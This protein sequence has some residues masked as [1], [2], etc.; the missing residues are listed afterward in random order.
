MKLARLAHIS[1][2]FIDVS[3]YFYL[4]A[5]SLL[6]VTVI[7][8]YREQ[9]TVTVRENT[10][11]N[12]VV[13]KVEARTFP[14]KHIITYAL[15]SENLKRPA[16]FSIN[17]KTGE[18]FVTGKLDRDEIRNFLLEVQASFQVSNTS[19]GSQYRSAKSFVL[20]N[21]REQGSDEGLS[22]TRSSYHLKVPCNVSQD[23]T[24]DRVRTAASDSIGSTRTRFRFQKRLD[25][26]FITHNGKIKT[27]R[28]LLLFCYNTPGKSFRTT[29]IARDTGGIRRNAYAL[30]QIVITPPGLLSKDIA[31]VAPDAK[32]TITRRLTSQSGA[33]IE[34]RK[35]N[36][37]STKK[38]ENTGTLP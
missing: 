22:F 25:Y 5:I 3:C 4:M 28:S 1:I 8:F 11:L 13:T 33:K 17:S 18:I 30:I 20:I 38:H 24:V 9:Y 16:L 29:I 23:T 6:F 2:G 14:K 31:G 7:S 32:D 21:V 37:L 34:Q 27:Q 10:Q 36:N 19:G 12:T 35:S 15:L 26:F